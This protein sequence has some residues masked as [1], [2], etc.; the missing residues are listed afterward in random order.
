MAISVQQL[1]IIA[2]FRPYHFDGN[3]HGFRSNGKIVIKIILTM[4]LEQQQLLSTQTTLQ[5][6]FFSF[7]GHSSVATPN[8][9]P[10]LTL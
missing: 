2:Q 8:I 9:S 6:I 7:Y 5:V 10:I 3:G 1:R 4:T